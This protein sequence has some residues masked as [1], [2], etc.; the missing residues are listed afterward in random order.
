[1]NTNRML[2]LVAVLLCCAGLSHADTPVADLDTQVGSVTH[3]FAVFTSDSADVDYL[4]ASSAG[5]TI[6]ATAVLKVQG[7]A[8]SRITLEDNE[9][10]ANVHVATVVNRAGESLYTVTGSF[11][12]GGAGTGESP[13]WQADYSK[14]ATQLSAFVNTPSTSD[15]E[16]PLTYPDFG[17][18]LTVSLIGVT[19]DDT[20][21]TVYL[22][23]TAGTPKV[24]FAAYQ[25]QLG[26]VGDAWVPT[27]TIDIAGKVLGT[28]TL[29]ADCSAFDEAHDATAG[30]EVK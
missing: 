17:G 8:D 4:Q 28:T 11:V 6:K 21:Y 29:K 1:M 24:A 13:T 9:G 19:E 27:A 22:S 18:T 23:D 26:R 30:V 2:L 16:I 20:T 10:Q 5:G 12:G 15:D 14:G 25:I 7:S 3:G